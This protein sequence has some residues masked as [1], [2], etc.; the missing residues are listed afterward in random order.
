METIFILLKNYQ[1]VGEAFFAGAIQVLLFMGFFA[2]VNAI[3]NVIQKHKK[4][5]DE[6][7]KDESGQS[8]CQ[9]KNWED[10]D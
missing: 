4:N 3:R 10:I 5:W 7:S 1:G 9:H 8:S 6:D 2:I